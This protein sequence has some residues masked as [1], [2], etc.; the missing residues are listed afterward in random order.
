MAGGRVKV[1]L[2]RI[3]DGQAEIVYEDGTTQT[4]V[5]GR[6]S[7]CIAGALVEGA[8]YTDV[9]DHLPLFVVG[10]LDGDLMGRLTP[11][12]RVFTPE[13]KLD[14]ALLL[15]PED[16]PVRIAFDDLE[17]P[18]NGV[19]VALSCSVADLRLVRRFTKRMDGIHMRATQAAL[20]RAASAVH[21]R[22]AMP[23]LAIAGDAAERH[24][25]ESGFSIDGNANIHL[26]SGA[27][28]QW[29]VKNRREWFAVRPVPTRL[30]I[31]D[32]LVGPNLSITDLVEELDGL[33]CPWEMKRFELLRDRPGDYLT[34]AALLEIELTP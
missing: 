23:S 28:S 13:P 11:F 32:D 5:A 20:D 8:G 31:L 33:G 34:P 14:G 3:S 12:D 16:D 6:A 17:M 18:V 7:P 1:G 21:D 2:L 10:S 4:A 15:G 29:S 19:S 9:A 27:L 30:V 24:V 25:R 22:G 26:L